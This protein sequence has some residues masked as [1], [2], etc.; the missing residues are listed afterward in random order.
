MKKYLLPEKGN[1][2][3]AELHIHTTVS[4]GTN[5]PE[6]LKKLHKEQGYSIIAITDHD[7]L[8]PHNE[9]TDENFLAITAAEWKVY[10][11]DGLSWAHGGWKA[12]HINV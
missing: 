4:D 5:T 11:S 2:Y 10:E 3:K 6:E 8:L 12:Y 9:L 1:Y 7:I